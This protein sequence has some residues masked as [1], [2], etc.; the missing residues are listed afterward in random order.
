MHSQYDIST[1]AAHETM[2][3]SFKR[4]E[5]ILLEHSVERPPSSIG[6]FSRDDVTSI[7]EH[8]VNHYFRHWKLYKYIYTAN[9][10]TSISASE[11]F[12]V[13]T[14]K[15]L[16]P[17]GEAVLMNDVVVTFPEQMEEEE[18]TAELV[19]EEEVNSNTLENSAEEEVK[20]A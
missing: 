8:V 16:L 14:P 11:C 10:R 13:E 20:M 3:N 4:F 17:L 6:V 19:R 7:L 9:L 15:K 18:E 12:F 1:N 5:K 2:E